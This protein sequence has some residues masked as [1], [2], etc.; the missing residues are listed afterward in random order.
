MEWW[1]KTMKLLAIIWKYRNKIPRQDIHCDF[2]LENHS[3]TVTMPS[4]IDIPYPHTHEGKKSTENHFRI[5]YFPLAFTANIH[6][7]QLCDY[8][9]FK[10]AHAH[11]T[12]FALLLVYLSIS[13]PSDVHARRKRSIVIIVSSYPNG[14][15]IQHTT[16]CTIQSTWNNFLIFN[17]TNMQLIQRN[18]PTYVCII[19]F[20]HYYWGK[21]MTKYFYFTNFQTIT[22]WM[23]NYGNF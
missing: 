1:E 13:L 17:F 23:L 14:I 20:G 5:A 2:M 22:F 16:R 19:C 11:T 18:C 6:C 4:Q 9:S 21:L 10:C 8:F 7:C 15:F 3:Y 12:I